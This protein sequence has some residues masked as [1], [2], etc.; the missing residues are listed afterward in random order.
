MIF[1]SAIGNGISVFDVDAGGNLIEGHLTSHNGTLT[2][3][4][5]EGLS[6]SEGDGIA[7]S[8][9]TFSGSIDHIN[10]ALE[11]TIFTPKP[12]FNG[13]AYIKIVTNDHGNTG[14]GGQK[15]DTSTVDISVTPVPD[16]PIAGDFDF[17]VKEDHV[18]TI[19]GWKFDDADGD[20][21]QSIKITAL[22]Q[23]GTLFL[24]SND[25]GQVDAGE[26]LSLNQIVSWADAKINPKV[27]YVGNPDYNGAD[28]FQYVVKDSSG[29]EGMAS[30]ETGMVNITIN[31][32]N[33]APVD[34]MPGLQ[35]AQ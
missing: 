22:P 21:A 29:S 19:S 23:H 20:A 18:K 30:T 7:D 32:V 6:F 13:D 24:D 3:A 1:S 8:D 4:R 15:Y 5:T 33:D 11:G 31:A 34:S 35:V 12:N 10:A 16:N 28:S 17:S 14:A 2:L 26:A 27:K 9:I 25:D